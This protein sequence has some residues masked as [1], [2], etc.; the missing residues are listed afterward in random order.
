ML[1]LKKEDW[2]QKMEICS[3]KF[4][5]WIMLPIFLWRKKCPLLPLLMSK[6]ESVMKN[7]RREFPSYQSTG[8][9]SMK[10]KELSQVLMRKHVQG[11]M[12]KFKWRRLLLMLS[13][14]E[15]SMKLM[16]WQ[17]QRSLK[18]QNSNCRPDFL[19]TNL[20]LINCLESWVNLKSQR[21][22][23]SLIFRK[24]ELSLIRLR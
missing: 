2:L 15:G 3:G 10:L 23:L 18:W 22:K 9:W 5:S 11:A 6:R 7:Q 16:V 19:K 14:G 12:F 8:T 20:P 17:E 13:F 21:T 1:K 4:K 24:W